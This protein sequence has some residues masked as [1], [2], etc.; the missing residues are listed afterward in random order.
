MLIA[1]SLPLAL[2]T[3]LNRLGPHWFGLSALAAVVEGAVA[4]RLL[5]LLPFLAEA[6]AVVHHELNAFIARLTLVRLNHIA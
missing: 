5:L 6:E 1:K 3:G 4:I 2:A